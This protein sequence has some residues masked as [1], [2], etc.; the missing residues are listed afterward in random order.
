MPNG[1]HEAGKHS[2]AGKKRA[3]ENPRLPKSDKKAKADPE[4]YS[5]T[6]YK[7]N[8]KSKRIIDKLLGD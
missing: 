6:V 8:S 7:S 3:A 5:G 4:T 2:A 1:Q